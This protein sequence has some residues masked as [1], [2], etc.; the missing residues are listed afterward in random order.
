MYVSCSIKPMYNENFTF[1]LIH[2]DVYHLLQDNEYQQAIRSVAS[3]LAPYDSDQ[4]IPVYGFGARLPPDGR[5]SHCFPLN[6]N[7]QKPEVYGVQVYSVANTYMYMCIGL[8]HLSCIVGSFMSDNSFSF[9]NN[10]LD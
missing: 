4:M 1:G 7:D 8:E 6:F 10:C 9:E 2:I 5:V 3:V